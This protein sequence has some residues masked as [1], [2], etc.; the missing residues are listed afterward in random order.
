MQ[1]TRPTLLLF[2]TLLLAA[3][4]LPA[5]PWKDGEAPPGP[6]V[7]NDRL[8]MLLRL[9]TPEQI[10]A[11]YEARGFPP[12][13][14]E[15]IRATCF[16][17]VHVD[18]K[19]SEVLWLETANW[20]IT[21]DGVPVSRLGRDHWNRVWDEIDLPQAKRSTFGWTQLPDVRDLQPTE[22]IGGNIVLPRNGRPYNI[23]ANFHTGANRRQ[24]MISV[25]FEN[26]HCAEDPPAP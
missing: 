10:S 1:I 24:G 23:R 2:A 8:F 3:G 9:Q 13:A 5:A 19:G 26:L 6:Y 22:P 16:F 25:D 4:A 12:E 7:D 11:F 18:N 14:L 15:R 17:T 21:Q 20:R